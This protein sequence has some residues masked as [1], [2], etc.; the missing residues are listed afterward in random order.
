MKGLLLKEFYQ[1][2]YYAKAVVLAVAA[3]MV[4]GVFMLP[5]GSFLTIYAGFLLGTM[6]M[7]LQAYDQTSGFGEY[8]AAL[9]VTKAQLTGSKYIIGLCMMALAVLMTALQ[10]LVGHLRGVAVDS[11][12][13]LAMI[14]QVMIAVLMNSTILMPLTYRFGYQKAKYLFYIMVGVFAGWLGFGVGSRDVGVFNLLPQNTPTAALLGILAGCL[15][16]YAVSW[17]LSAAWYGKA[18]EKA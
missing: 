13:V 2:W 15:V 9:P 11:T 5:G 3:M 8:G 10:L 7:T 16:L 18:G 6:P 14:T 17:R 12:M 4:A 1:M